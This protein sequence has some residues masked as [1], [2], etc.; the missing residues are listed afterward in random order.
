MGWL[1]YSGNIDRLQGNRPIGDGDC[2]DLVQKLTSI[3]HTSRWQRGPRVVEM[4]FLNPGTVIANFVPDGRGG[5]K[6]PNRHGSHAAFFVEFA[7]RFLNG[8]Q[9][10]I[11]VMDQFVNR[12]PKNE[13]R[14][15]PIPSW[16]MKSKAEG[17]MYSDA[18]N[19][20]QYFVVM[21]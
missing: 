5:W 9:A 15:R 13:V 1:I 17:N 4:A 3:G 6:F 16:G 18:D 14:A 11:V 7:G 20:D 2:V 21:V 12:V 19:A 10:G 8:R